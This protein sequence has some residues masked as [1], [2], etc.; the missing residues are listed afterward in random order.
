[1]RKTCNIF[2]KTKMSNETAA[3]TTTPVNEADE[4][5][6]RL[7]KKSIETYR[8]YGEQPTL[9]DIESCQIDEQSNSN[10]FLQITPY[11]ATMDLTKLED[12]TYTKSYT[13]WLNEK[14]VLF[15][16]NVNFLK[17]IVRRLSSP[18]NEYLAT[19]V[20][21]TKNDQEIQYFQLWKKNHLVHSYEI[22][23]QSPHGKI[24]GKNDYASFFEW[25][26]DSK[27][28]IF[29]AEEKRKPIK[30]YFNC[31]KLDDAISNPPNLYQENWGEQMESFE[32]N[33]VCL[34]DVEK[35]EVKLI[36]NLPK[37][38]YMGQ[39]IWNEKCIDEVIFIGY[40]VEPYRLGLI[41]CEN[42]ASAFFHCN[43]KQNECKQLNE[44]DQLCRLH[45][46][47]IPNQENKLI[48]LQ[49]DIYKGHRQCQRL[50]LYDW[51]KNEEKILVERVE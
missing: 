19:V 17:N 24:N 6:K 51:I 22:D 25:S 30:S 1:I 2:F 15:E 43:W 46:R 27:Y 33:C 32:L 11:F 20:K 26:P 18:N 38:V 50:V 9:A 23:K 29:T 13:Y 12:L 35:K 48:Y 31:D 4:H 49:C 42:R 47:S 7:I 28:L 34:F 41:Y 14:K 16:S 40:P 8:C 36:E 21:E 5:R 44:F 39:A 45:P 10:I 37:N 3:S